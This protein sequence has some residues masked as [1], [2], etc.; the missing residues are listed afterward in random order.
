[1]VAK[2]AGRVRDEVVDPSGHV[3]AMVGD[4]V[5]DVVGPEVGEVVGR[6][7]GSLE[8]GS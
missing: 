1:M 2:H 7:L 3:G 5:G 4:N 8:T 6:K